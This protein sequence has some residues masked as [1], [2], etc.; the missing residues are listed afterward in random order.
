MQKTKLS[1]ET[2]RGNDRLTVRVRDEISRTTIVS[3]DLNPVET[4]WFLGGT[5]VETDG[6][7]TENFDRVGKTMKT[8]A[9]VYSSQDLRASTY[10]QLEGDAEAMARADRPG[11]DTYSARRTNTGSVRVVMRRWE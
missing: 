10:D 5:H 7:V 1:L 9:V 8:D 3:F 4:W 2:T 6:Q 11:W